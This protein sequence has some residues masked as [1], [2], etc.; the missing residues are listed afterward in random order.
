VKLFLFIILQLAYFYYVNSECNFTIFTKEYHLVS[1]EKI[2]SG[3]ETIHIKIFSKVGWILVKLF[4][5]IILQLAYLYYVNSECNFTI[6]TKENHLGSLEKIVQQIRNHSHK[7]FQQGWLNTCEV[8]CVH[9]IV[10]S[11]F[12]LCKFRA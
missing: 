5:F 6:F 10:F 12:L 1:L 4:V 3:S 8:I 9:Y 11:L 7:N 2:F